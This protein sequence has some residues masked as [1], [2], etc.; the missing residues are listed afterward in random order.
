MTILRANPEFLVN[1]TTASD[2]NVS[3]IAAM[4]DGRFVVTWSDF[5]LSG[6]DTSGFAIRARIFNPMAASPNPSSG[7]ILPRQTTSLVAASSPLQTA[8]SS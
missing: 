2:Q 8:G 7:S 5:S 6:G 3:S 4:A 1:T